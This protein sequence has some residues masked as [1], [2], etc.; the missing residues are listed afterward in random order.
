[1][2]GSPDYAMSVRRGQFPKVL[3]NLH[4]PVIPLYSILMLLVL[5]ILPLQVITGGLNVL[6]ILAQEVSSTPRF[7]LII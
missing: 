6:S 4:L 2:S 5:A 3:R 7:L 1:M